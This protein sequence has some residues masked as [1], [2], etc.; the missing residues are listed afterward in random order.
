[1]KH[2]RT[3]LLNPLFFVGFLLF[4][5]AFAIDYQ[6]YFENFFIIGISFLPLSLTLIQAT[7][8]LIAGS[9]LRRLISRKSTKSEVY[10]GLGLGIISIITSLIGLGVLSYNFNPDPILDI[11]ILLLFT[12][13]SAFLFSA[14]SL[15]IVKSFQKMRN[16]TP[17]AQLEI[18]FSQLTLNDLKE[19]PMRINN[20][21]QL[22]FDILI[23]EK[24]E[25]LFRLY[26]QYAPDT[27][28][29]LIKNNDQL[30]QEIILEAIKKQFIHF[31]RI[32]FDNRNY[33]ATYQLLECYKKIAWIFNNNPDLVGNN[34]LNMIN[35]FEESDRLI[36]RIFLDERKYP[37]FNDDL[38]AL[39]V[40]LPRFLIELIQLNLFKDNFSV[41]CG[42]SSLD[43]IFLVDQKLPKISQMR[44]YYYQVMRKKS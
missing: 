37:F 4:D 15:P 44:I 22:I 34:A 42:L 28:T 12:V 26:K 10:F 25:R 20:P 11:L 32:L 39:Y 3:L 1:M 2:D 18:A 38:E 19:D 43:R 29:R 9:E 5:I 30:D 6:F 35:D 23:H 17:D 8:S 33:L 31:S 13:S 16:L 24:D 14:F 41:N 7:L 40:Y 27:I 21:Q 36:S